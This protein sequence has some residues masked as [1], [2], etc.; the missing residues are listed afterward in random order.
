MVARFGMLSI[1]P[2][3]PMFPWLTCAIATG[4]SATSIAAIM[5]YRIRVFLFAYGPG[6]AG[7]RHDSRVGTARPSG[8]RLVHRF[9]QLFPG[10]LWAD[11]GF[12][13][14]ALPQPELCI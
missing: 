11:P 8:G 13:I 7:G 14:S 12:R 5:V 4:V 2:N 3:P 9:L 10:Y 6:M 1:P